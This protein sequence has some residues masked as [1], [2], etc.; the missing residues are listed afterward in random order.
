MSFIKRFAEEQE[1]ID[2]R[3][4]ALEALLDC[5]LLD[6]AAAGIAKKVIGENSLDG[7]SAKQ[8]GVY[9]TVI[10]PQ[11]K[12]RCDGNCGDNIPMETVAEAIRYSVA[13]D[14]YYCP[15]CE[16]SHRERKDD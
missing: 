11:L 15:N 4:E 10:Y 8:K 3:N 7:L 5:D 14:K 13:G 2:N 6:G 16:Y 9:E 12:V 1:E